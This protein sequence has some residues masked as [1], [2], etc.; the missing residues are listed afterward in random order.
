MATDS[1]TPAEALPTQSRPPRLLTSTA[2]V[3]GAKSYAM[4]VQLALSPFIIAQIGLSAYGFWAIVSA[5]V[6]YAAILD[7]GVGPALAR[8]IAS[9]HALNEADRITDQ[10]RA[11]FALVTPVSVVIVAL[12]IGVTAVL[13]DSITAS[14][15]AGW[16][17]SVIGVTICLACMLW[18]SPNMAFARGLGRFDLDAVAPSVYQTTFAATTVA[19]LLSG[20]G[21]AG[22]GV[23]SAIGGA[24]MLVAAALT[25]RIVWRHPALPW[26]AT[27]GDIGDLARYGG[28][29]QVGALMTVVNTQADK[30]MILLAGGSLEFVALY[31]LGSKVAFQLRSLPITAL[32]PLTI[33]FVH[34]VAGQPLTALRARYDWGLQTV[35]RWMVAP[36]V[37][38][39]GAC[40]PLVLAWLGTDFQTAATIMLV[41]S[42]GYAVNLGTAAGT[43][44]ANAYG[45]PQFDRDYSTLALAI[46]LILSLALGLLLGPWGVVAATAAGLVLSAAWL[47]YSVAR[48][49]ADGDSWRPA[50]LNRETAR[51]L[52][53]AVATAV[54]TVMLTVGLEPNRLGAFG[55]GAAASAALFL[56][57]LARWRYR[58]PAHW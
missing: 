44:L 43:T 45:R 41:L 42:V 18:A 49:I 5:F 6:S 57:L 10:G 30:P 46:N 54:T 35:L 22:L 58:Q 26:R 15:P 40:F 8:Y 39:S 27:R 38:L 13:P 53:L 34:D 16:E 2:Y 37:A 28:N 3:A 32:G 33:R 31:E 56:T 12:G 55:I 29:L 9:H 21:L 7:L 51:V 11:A 36:V 50:A 24:S 4:V 52:L 20:Y 47:H 14:W 48:W 17:V 25:R 1:G 23:A 19:A